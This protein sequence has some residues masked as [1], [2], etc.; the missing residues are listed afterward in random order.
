[1]ILTKDQILEMYLNSVY[2]GQG[3]GRG[4]A[5][6]A[7][8]ARW[9]FDTPVDSLQLNDAALLA[10]MIPS[11]NVYSPFKNPKLARELRILERGVDV[12]RGNHRGE[13]RGVVQLQRIDRRVE[14][15][16]RRLGHAGDAA[17]FALPE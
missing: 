16:A 13:Q 17:A 11:P 3:E 15:P 12:G 8:A 9:Y 7:E 5:G 10:A 4:V 14:V 1:M 2:L 6:V